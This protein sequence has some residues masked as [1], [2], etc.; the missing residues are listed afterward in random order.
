MSLFGPAFVIFGPSVMIIFVLGNQQGRT[1]LKTASEN[2]SAFVWGSFL[3]VVWE[4]PDF[5]NVHPKKQ[6]KI[7]SWEC[8]FFAPRLLF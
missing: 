1:Q 2:I 8:H 3:L 6:N 5:E 7:T 4:F